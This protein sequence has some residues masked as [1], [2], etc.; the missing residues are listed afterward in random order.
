MSDVLVLETEQAPPTGTQLPP[1]QPKWTDTLAYIT[2]PDQFCRHN[3]KEHGPIFRTSVFGGTTIFVGSSRAV[4]MALN[5]DL[6]YTE[7]G[8]PQTTMTM[9]GEYSLFQR[10]DLHRQR[11]S[12]LRAGLAG[13]AIQGYIPKINDVIIQR[14]QTWPAQGEIALFPAV[15]QICFDV[16]VPLLLGVEL[17]DGCFQGLPIPSKAGLKQ[18]YKTFFDGFYGL[19]PWRSSFTTFGRGLQARARLIKFMQAVI[20][21]RQSEIN[22]DPTADF[23][24]MMLVSQQTDPESVFSN[25]LIENQCLLQLWASHYEISGLVSSWIYQLGRHPEHFA[26]LRGEQATIQAQ[27]AQPL[28]SEQLKTT[29]F[30]DATLQETL[31]TL[32][33]SSTANRRLTQSVVLDGVLYEKG[34]TLIAEPRIAHILPEHFPQPD[35]FQPNRFL[36]NANARDKYAYIPFGGGVHACLGAQL[37]MTIAKIFGSHLLRQFEWQVQGTAPFVQFPLKKIKDSYPMQIARLQQP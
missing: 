13:Q 11:K 28:T 33:P 29:S 30:L 25:T 32:P 18:V 22:L 24:S 19:L 6:R 35:A 15:E 31:R 4:Q 1:R 14:L 37:A 23:L 9:F 20:H 3:L 17:D 7:I 5:G 8:L 36:E 2:N 21:R 27:S 26:H 10:P 12:A 34:W 16:L